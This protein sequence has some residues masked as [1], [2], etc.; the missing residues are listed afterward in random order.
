[1]VYYPQPTMSQVVVLNE[2]Y[3]VGGIYLVEC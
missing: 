1:M 2:I 3:S